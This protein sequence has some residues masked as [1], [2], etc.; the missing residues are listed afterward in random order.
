MSGDFETRNFRLVISREALEDLAHND[1][2]TPMLTLYNRTDIND[3]IYNIFDKLIKLSRFDAN[4]DI[5]IR[6]E[7][8]I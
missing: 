8:I 2:R 7:D 6:A 3:K 4:G 1:G 5:V